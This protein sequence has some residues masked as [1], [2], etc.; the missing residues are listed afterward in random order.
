MEN[1][2]KTPVLPVEAKAI[3]GERSVQAVYRR[4]RLGQLP[5]V[6]RIGRN[7]RFNRE[8]LLAFVA[9]SKAA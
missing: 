5:G 4:A 2:V 1:E 9:G 3:L 8:A 6:I 7:V